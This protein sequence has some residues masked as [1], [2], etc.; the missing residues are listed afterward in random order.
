ME[1]VEVGEVLD[2][3]LKD[4]PPTQEKAVIGRFTNPDIQY[5]HTKE[6][7]DQ[8]F[9]RRMLRTFGETTVLEAL[10]RF[11]NGWEYAPRSKEGLFVSLC[12][13]VESV[14]KEER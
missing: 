11:A 12:K 5:L 7:L 4:H 8:Q 9:I 6:G 10:R 13:A 14:G 3:L 2:S 1:E